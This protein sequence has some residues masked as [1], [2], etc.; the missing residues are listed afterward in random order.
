MKII[1]FETKG[2]VIRF[3]LGADD[4]D[5]YWGDDWND[6][7]LDNA[8]P[9]YNR[10]VTGY[11]TVFVPFDYAV[12]DIRHDWHYQNPY[13]PGLTKEDFKL[14]HWPCLI[15]DVSPEWFTTY[16]DA[17]FKKDSIRFYFN[18]TLEPGTYILDN[19]S[20]RPI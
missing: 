2:N 8:G 18:Y 11:A 9:V 13:G 14:E 17:E 20:L 7:S 15:V 12:C 16:Y 10:Y 4:C 3:A 1:D 6:F 19:T 5:D